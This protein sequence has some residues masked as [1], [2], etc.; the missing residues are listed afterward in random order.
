MLD[1]ATPTTCSC[2]ACTLR[3]VLHLVTRF[4]QTRNSVRTY[5]PYQVLEMALANFSDGLRNVEEMGNIF[6]ILATWMLENS[7]NM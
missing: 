4:A 7:L 5:V 2:M 6:A 3:H 1:G